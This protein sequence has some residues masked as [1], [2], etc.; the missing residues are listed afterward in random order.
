MS[1]EEVY[2]PPRSPEFVRVMQLTHQ[3]ILYAMRNPEVIERYAANLHVTAE[4][5]LAFMIADDLFE[6]FD[7]SAK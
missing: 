3:H 2:N 5:A 4:T 7:I 6:Q 1:S